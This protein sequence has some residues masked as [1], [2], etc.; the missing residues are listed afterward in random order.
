VVRALADD[1]DLLAHAAAAHPLA[2]CA[3]VVAVAVHMGGVEGGAAEFEHLVEQ[4]E[5]GVDVLRVDHD[6]SLDQA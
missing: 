1:H 2:H 3:L 6:R 4:P 5:A